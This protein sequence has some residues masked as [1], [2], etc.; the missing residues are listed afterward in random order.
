MAF[1]SKLRNM[2]ES[3]SK[4]RHSLFDYYEQKNNGNERISVLWQA[5]NKK[6][7]CSR[8]C[9][10]IETI[11]LYVNLLNNEEEMFFGIGVRSQVASTSNAIVAIR[12]KKSHLVA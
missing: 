11:F 8:F 6:S 2:E 12:N 1:Y 5:N 3:F 9:L 4:M 7:F 10:Q